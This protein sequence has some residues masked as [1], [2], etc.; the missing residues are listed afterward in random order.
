L[1]QQGVGSGIRGYIRDLNRAHSELATAE[2][3]FIQQTGSLEKEIAR[4]NSE[5]QDKST[6]IDEINAKFG[7]PG[8]R[9]RN[10]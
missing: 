4:L 3:W 5:P 6:M 8:T 7:A 2:D 9:K 10:G 1:G